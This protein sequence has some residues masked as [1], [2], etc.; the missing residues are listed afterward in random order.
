MIREPEPEHMYAYLGPK[1][2]L[3][4][5]KIWTRNLDNEAEEGHSSLP[6]IFY[7]NSNYEKMKNLTK[8]QGKLTPTIDKVVSRQLDESG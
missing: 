2:M 6:P 1:M 3:H 5:R 4:K 7:I 8:D